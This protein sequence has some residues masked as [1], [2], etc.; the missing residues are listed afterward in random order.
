MVAGAA[1]HGSACRVD[2]VTDHLANRRY[3]VERLEKAG[4]NHSLE[5]GGRVDR[6]VG[7]QRG[8]GGVDLLLDGTVKRREVRLEDGN[9]GIDL[10]ERKRAL[11]LFSHAKTYV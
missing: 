6:I 7:A 2:Q 3:G 1:S 5:I 11:D 9:D 10:L 4:D 8:I